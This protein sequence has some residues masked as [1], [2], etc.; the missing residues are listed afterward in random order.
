[1]IK[2]LRCDDRLIHGQCVTKLVSY[3]DVQ[4]IIVVDNFT[5]T[6][7][8]MKKIF[9]SAVPKGIRGI[10]VTVDGAVERLKE[11]KD[12]DRNTIVLMKTPDIMLELY[13][14]EP[15][16]PKEFNIASVPASRGKREITKF[17]YLDE[18]QLNAVKEMGNKGVHIWFQ[19]IPDSGRT[20]WDQI[21]EKYE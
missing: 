8:V 5:A 10:V 1:M 9:E 21:R 16:L 6:N 7:T 20:E 4:D 11:A 13:N 15:S 2:L 14:R 19:L 17:A 12:N 3:Y 18:K